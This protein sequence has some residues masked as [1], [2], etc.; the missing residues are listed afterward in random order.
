MKK[1]KYSIY[2]ILTF[3]FLT[4]LIPAFTVLCFNLDSNKIIAITSAVISISGGGIASV[5]VAWLIDVANTKRNK[6]KKA[7][8]LN[9][10]IRDFKIAVWDF[11]GMYCEACCQN[12][13]SLQ[14][15]KHNFEEWGKIYINQIESGFEQV[16][17]KH[18]V[19]Q[20]EQVEEAYK[21]IEKNKVLFIESDIISEDELR[22]VYNISLTIVAYKGDYI[23]RDKNVSKENIEELI[24]YLILYLKEYEP[25]S[26]IIDMKICR[27]TE[28]PY[29]A[30]FYY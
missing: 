20:I 3:A 12:D 14:E 22:C 17:G 8:L 1:S 9:I 27:D 15:Q 10:L 6:Q 2:I 25:M 21:D 19:Y 30:E 26:E 24:K 13:E 23:L 7:A 4:V 16:E 18:F 11:C 5:L 29:E 28:N